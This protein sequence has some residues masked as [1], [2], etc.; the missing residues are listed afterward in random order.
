LNKFSSGKLWKKAGGEAA[1]KKTKPERSTGHRNAG[2]KSS[3]KN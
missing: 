2:G 1:E 3:R